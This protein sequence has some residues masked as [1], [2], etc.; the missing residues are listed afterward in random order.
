M[1]AA[2]GLTS[3]LGG[4]LKTGMN[5]A[6][7]AAQG[8]LRL[9][10]LVA[11]IR[12]EHHRKSAL[13]RALRGSLEAQ[14]RERSRLFSIGGAGAGRGRPKSEPLYPLQAARIACTRSATCRRASVRSTP[15][16]SSSS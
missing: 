11:E 16:A 8:I 15:P 7:Q 9:Q 5:E 10:A 3:G 12:R 1:P 13:C 14:D 4:H 6:L 2:A